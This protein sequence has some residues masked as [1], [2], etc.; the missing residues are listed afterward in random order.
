MKIKESPNQCVRDMDAC[1]AQLMNANHLTALKS[2]RASTQFR[3]LVN[4]VPKDTLTNFKRS[5]QRLDHFYAD[6]LNQKEEYFELWQAVKLILLFSHGNAFVKGGFS[7]NKDMLVENLLEENL[8]AMRRAYDGILH[9]GGDDKVIVD[10]EMIRYARG[11][12]A[13]YKQEQESR[14]NQQRIARLG[15]SQKKNRKSV[16]GL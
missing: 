10:R 12:H 1:L 11:A 14:K 8:V 9:C 5:S 2:D 3:R 7:L 6:L 16:R 4:D 13:K 15:K